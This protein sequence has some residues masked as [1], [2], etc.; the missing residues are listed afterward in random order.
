MS[1]KSSPELKAKRNYK[2]TVFR[3]VFKE[4]KELLELYN[5]VNGT[6]YQ[7]PEEL[8]IITLENAIYMSMKNDVSCCLHMNLQ[9]YEQQSTVNPNMPIRFLLYFVEQLKQLLIH[10]DVYSRKRINLPTP[11]FF[12]FYNGV[13]DEPECRIMKL[14]DSFIQ[15][16]EKYFLDL[17]AYQYNINPGYN[18]SLKQKCPTLMEYME[19]VSKVRKYRETISLTEAVGKAVDECIKEGILKEFLL[20]NK[21]E[22]VSMSIYE[23]DQEKHNRTLYSEGY[24]DGE[25]AGRQEG[26]EEGIAEGRQEV[27][28]TMVKNMRTEGISCELISKVTGISMEEIQSI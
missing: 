25:L 4:K 22:V 6:N 27:I 13:E 1:K 18:E 28:F 3:M 7:N 14:S 17:V 24:E 5:G 23:Y 15:K 19:Y 20:K 26:R 8:K 2:D 10:W 21:A 11:K 16:E 12:V 9:L